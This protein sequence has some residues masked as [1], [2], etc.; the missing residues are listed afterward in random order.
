MKNLI[1]KLLT[2]A[3]FTAATLIIA[4]PT[5]IKVFSWLSKSFSKVYM[6]KYNRSFLFN[7]CFSKA[8][9]PY[10]TNLSSTVGS[11]RFTAS[12]RKSIKIPNNIL[13]VFI[14]IILSDANISK[15]NKADA[16]LQFKQTI[17]NIRYFYSV[18]YK[19]SHYCSKGPYITRTIV[20]KNLQIGLGVT[21]RS[22]PC[23]TELYDL[24]YIDNIK[25]IP[26][27]LFD[28]LSWE[29]LAHWISG[30]GTYNSGVRIQT[31][32]FTVKEVV[33]IVNVLII[34]FNLECSLHKQRDYYIVYIKSK[35]LKKN[36]PNL[37]PY[38]DNSMKYKL[39]GKKFK[40]CSLS[41]DKSKAFELITVKS[42]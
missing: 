21:T 4:V 25:R 13:P 8:L 42:L 37:L 36:I 7:L 20:H 34:K 3:Y 40:Y 1:I 24:F 28:L 5:G 31:E 38:M 33:F 30:D 27:N 18:F 39:L 26:H 12:E 14:G 23:I 2:R 17:K 9:V 35:S 41:Y 15:S 29:A 10:G 19:L 22:L 6:T 16:R 32:C 11:P